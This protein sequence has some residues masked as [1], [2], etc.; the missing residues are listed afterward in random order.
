MNKS[1]V[2]ELDLQA[3]QAQVQEL[4]AQLLHMSENQALHKQALLQQIANLPTVLAAASRE[5]QQ[6]PA[7]DDCD[8]PAK[9]PRE[10]F[11]RASSAAAPARPQI[12]VWVLREYCTVAE[13]YARYLQ[14]K[15]CIKA[16]L[17]CQGDEH[18]VAFSEF[19]LGLTAEV[20]RRGVEELERLTFKSQPPSTAGA[21]LPLHKW[22]KKKPCARGCPLCKC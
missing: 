10:R 19:H 22:R 20:A 4:G 13:A 8:R 7:A 5:G 18:K 3:L 16:A 1:S 21:G 17:S 15:A 11:C 6:A 9:Q 12:L 2:L 14:I